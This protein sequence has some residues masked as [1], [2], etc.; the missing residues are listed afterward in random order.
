[1]CFCNQALVLCV[2][3]SDPPPVEG[4]AECVVKGL[5][6]LQNLKLKRIS[7]MYN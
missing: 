7:G 1:M 5:R 4:H 3:V 2:Q 6:Y